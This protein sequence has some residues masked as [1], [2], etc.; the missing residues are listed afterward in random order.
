MSEWK[1]LFVDVK[2]APKQ[3]PSPK[4][5]PKPVLTPEEEL[6][7]RKERNARSRS[8]TKR[9]LA[10]KAG[11]RVGSKPM[12]RTIPK[13]EWERYI[14]SPVW[15]RRRQRYY[16]THER[17]CAVCGTAERVELHHLAYDR[18]G[19]NEPD[20]D[21]MPLCQRHHANV[22]EFYQKVRIYDLRAATH[23]FVA[24]AHVRLR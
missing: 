10:K 5:K 17:R 14:A 8:R 3:K 12:I 19:G 13:L 22:H 7:R 6:Q 2:P 21:L 20:A 18:I 23:R 9:T 4:R 16:E 24:E 15:H 11:Q 1:P